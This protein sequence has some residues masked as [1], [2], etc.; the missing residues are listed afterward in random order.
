MTGDDPR[1]ALAE[2]AAVAEL[3]HFGHLPDRAMLSAT[4]ECQPK[5]ATTP[6]IVTESVTDSARPE[7]RPVTCADVIDLDTVRIERGKDFESQGTYRVLAGDSIV[8][9]YLG[10]DRRRRWEARTSTT[11]LTV[12]G[13][14]WRTRKDALVHL[15]MDGGFATNTSNPSRKPIAARTKE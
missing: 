10:R 4:V 13:G 15:L 11:A 7:A 12:R 5:R 3:A 14:P 6:N 1:A 8:L 2:L 9:G